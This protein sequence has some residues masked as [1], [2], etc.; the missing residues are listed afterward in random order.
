[1]ATPLDLNDRT[2]ELVAALAVANRMQRA[3]VS[4]GQIDAILL[5]KY[6]LTKSGLTAAVK[7]MPRETSPK[8]LESK[9]LFRA[10][11]YGLTLGWYDEIAGLIGA[12]KGTGYDKAR[13][14]AQRELKR[15]EQEHPVLANTMKGLGATVAFGAGAGVARGAFAALSGAG[16]GFGLPTMF[17]SE[18]P[19]LPIAARA[20]AGGVGGAAAGAG[21]L[22]GGESEGLAERGQGAAGGALLGAF[23]ATAAGAVTPRAAVTAGRAAVSPLRRL[24]PWIGGAGAGLT[25]KKLLDYLSQRQSDR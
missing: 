15:F 17:G 21:G 13:R 6:G 9:D 3:G 14:A 2:K 25:G 20:L 12:L 16:R 24:L 7:A 11:A 4:P 23:G 5:S 8:P 19:L 10:Q 1:M 22:V 18:A